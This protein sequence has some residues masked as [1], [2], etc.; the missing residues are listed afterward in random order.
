M[1]IARTL[2][3]MTSSQLLV[4]GICHRTFSV[5]APV[6]G[7]SKARMY[8]GLTIATCGVV[9]ATW[10]DFHQEEDHIPVTLR[11]K[12]TVDMYSMETQPDTRPSQFYIEEPLKVTVRRKRTEFDI[13]P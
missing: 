3:K 2:T 11:R 12:S 10:K 4:S 5:A 9:G 7:P 1:M 6:A 8:L 13:P